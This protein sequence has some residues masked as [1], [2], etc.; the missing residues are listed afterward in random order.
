MSAKYQKL[1]AWEFDRVRF[2]SAIVE[3]LSIFNRGEL[4]E[5]TGV[6]A[7]TIDHW[8]RGQFQNDFPYPSMTNFLIVC[9]ELDINPTEMFTLEDA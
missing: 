7:T 8:S 6:H 1:M 3:C 2:Q 9:N 5:I 4:A